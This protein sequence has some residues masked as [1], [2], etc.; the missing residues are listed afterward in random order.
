MDDLQD[1][2]DEAADGVWRF[3]NRSRR[4]L[5]AQDDLN[6]S[7]RSSSSRKIGE[8]SDFAFEWRYI[9]VALLGD[10]SSTAVGR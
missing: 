3:F 9:A 2:D 1:E 10:V 6:S 4:E 5:S 7:S 8:S